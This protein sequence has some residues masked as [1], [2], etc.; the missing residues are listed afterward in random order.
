MFGSLQEQKNDEGISVI[1]SPGARPV[2]SSPETQVHQWVILHLHSTYTQSFSGFLMIQLICSLGHEASA[3]L[4]KWD[5]MRVTSVSMTALKPQHRKWDA[6]PKSHSSESRSRDLNFCLNYS[7][8][9]LAC[10]GL[11]WSESKK[12]HPAS[13]PSPHSLYPLPA[14]LQ[15]P[16]MAVALT[17]TMFSVLSLTIY[18]RFL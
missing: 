12:E 6:Y 11:R 10:G 16:P 8:L 4:N 14:W 5:Q 1:P 2:L 17:E 18:P 15:L 13:F 9:T 7:I 3:M